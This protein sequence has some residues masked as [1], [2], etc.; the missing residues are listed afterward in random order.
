ML[1]KKSGFFFVLFA[2][3]AS[4]SGVDWIYLLSRVIV[5]SSLVEIEVGSG[6]CVGADGTRW[7]KLFTGWNRVVLLN[8]CCW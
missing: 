1:G 6:G 8:L 5:V 7:F 4:Q 3:T 2:V